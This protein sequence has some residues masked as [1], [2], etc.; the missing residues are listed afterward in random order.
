MEETKKTNN[1]TKR[2]KLKKYYECVYCD[3]NTCKKTDYFRHLDTK[4]FKNKVKSKTKKRK[5]KK[6]KN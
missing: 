2:G 3:F 6:H 1:I 4:T 5:Y